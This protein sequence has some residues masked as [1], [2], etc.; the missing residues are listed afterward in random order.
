MDGQRNLVPFLQNTES[1]TPH[2]TSSTVLPH[3]QA[4]RNLLHR[5]P[6]LSQAADRPPRLCNAPSAEAVSVVTYELY[7]VGSLLTTRSYNFL[8]LKNKKAIIWQPRMGMTVE[9]LG[10]NLMLFRFYNSL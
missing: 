9:D 6:C 4:A 1:L 5:T 10:T 3:P 8:A 7:A 2:S